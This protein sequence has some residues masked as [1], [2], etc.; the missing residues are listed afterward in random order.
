MNSIGIGSGVGVSFSPLLGGLLDSFTSLVDGVLTTTDGETGDLTFTLDSTS[1][2]YSDNTYGPITAASITPY[3]VFEDGDLV[4]DSTTGTYTLPF[5]IHD[6]GLPVTVTYEL[7]LDGVLFGTQ[8]TFADQPDG[9]KTFTMPTDAG[10]Y[11]IRATVDFDGTVEVLTST[12]VAVVASGDVIADSNGVTSLTGTNDIGADTSG[13]LVLARIELNALPAANT[14]IFDLN[15]GA[16]LS[17]FTDGELRAVCRVGS[18]NLID[19]RTSSADDLVVGAEYVIALWADINGT[20]SLYI[21]ADGAAFNE[22]ATSTRTGT[23]LIDLSNSTVGFG[24]LRSGAEVID[25]NA[26]QYWVKKYAAMPSLTE[27]E[28]FASFAT[29]ASMTAEY[30][31]GHWDFRGTLAEWNAADNKGTGADLARNGAE[32]TEAT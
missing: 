19:L 1:G 23:D 6:E 11:T 3:Y 29:P 7:M 14:R 22:V 5:V 10:D 9:T 8:P 28:R 4:S 26:S 31:A 2:A 30:G 24:S 21:S 16:R 18:S 20:S 12:I 15:N 25:C 32:Y 13:L 17:L 27:A